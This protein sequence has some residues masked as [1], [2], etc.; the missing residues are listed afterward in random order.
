[1]KI[2]TIHSDYVNFEPTKKAIKSAEE[3]S[4]KKEEMKDCLVVF[5]AVE[6][7]DE[8]DLKGIVNKYIDE[9]KKVAQQVKTNKIVIYPYA[10]LSSNLS[11]PDFAVEVLKEAE[12]ILSKD[13]KV[14]R[15][16]FGWYKKFEISCKGHPLSE[17]SREFSVV[18]QAKPELKEEPCDPKKLLS[19]ITKI[20]LDTS[21]LK[22]ND[23]RILGQKL[24]LFSFNEV[25]P[26]MVFWHNNGLIIFN[27][28]VNYWRDEKNLA[29]YQEIS[30]PQIMDKRLWQISGHWDKYK[31]NNFVTKYE[32]TPM[33][34][35][36]MSCPGGMLVY[37]NKPK[38]YKELPLRVAELGKV[39][40]VELSG[41]LGGLFRVIQFTQDDAHVFCEEK[42]IEGEISN[43]MDMIF[44]MY[45]KLN[46]EFDHVELST[47]PEKR[48][49]SEATWDKAEA[50]LES[51]LKKKKTNYKVNKGDGA[52]Y[53]PK[54]DFHVKDSQGRTW[55]TS[56]IQLDFNMPERFD[57]E[58]IGEDNKP[59]RPAM[60][61][62]VVYGA[63]ERFLG[64][65][66]EHTNANL[67]VWLSPIQAR[68]IPFNEGN[69]KSANKLL[70][71]L[72][73]NG[74]RVD[75]D[76]DNGTI[77][78]KIRNAELMKIPYVLVL[79]DKEEK[80]GLVSVRNKSS[81]KV[82]SLKKSEFLSQ[83][84]KEINYRE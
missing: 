25:A 30:T 18:Q 50:I 33:L 13:Y 59:H 63:I 16:P 17:L 32:D 54:I 60:L 79:G 20:R 68:V 21:K 53:G 69:V 74:I 72:K 26:G 67:P 14:L 8:P 48:V 28:L 27:E 47:R 5:S 70:E 31:E 58:Y 44:R 3:I 6:K 22:E 41:T 71:E 62:Y 56:T 11:N 40:R 84:L 1:M 73:E 35:K 42:Q 29:G 24:D 61:H 37:K 45:K 34:V 78:N 75:I 66:L 7:N 51:L 49:G 81:K 65:Y 46:I 2:L 39:H 19:E 23:H 55:Q 82:S 43:I 36:P 64:I 80:E 52:F 15:A 4:M 9:I 57:L 83:M 10:H 12:K 76:L 38:S 77:N